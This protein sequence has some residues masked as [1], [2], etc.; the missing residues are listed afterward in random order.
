M[1]SPSSTF[2][3]LPPPLPTVALHTALRLPPD[4]EIYTGLKSAAALLPRQSL[5]VTT[6]VGSVHTATLRLANASGHNKNAMKTFPADERF[7]VLSLVGTLSRDGVHL[8]VSLGD[9]DGKVWG[10]HLVKATVYTTLEVVLGCFTELQFERVYDDRTGFKELRVREKAGQ[11]KATMG[12]VGVACAGA[13]L[14]MLL[15]LA[16]RKFYRH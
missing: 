9:A 8:H 6:A 2:L 16:I 12:T 13:G 1:A 11:N 10:G 4:V 7:E 5:F 15:S 3:S 14:G